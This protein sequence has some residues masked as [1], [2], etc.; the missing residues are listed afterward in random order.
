M[1][2][3]I[4]DG[5]SAL[6]GYAGHVEISADFQLLENTTAQPPEVMA[7]LCGVLIGY[8]NVRASS[9]DQILS[10][11]VVTETFVFFTCP[12]RD[13]Y[14]LVQFV[15]NKKLSE[16]SESVFSILRSGEN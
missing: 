4:S 8:L 14:L 16:A 1:R 3:N 6:A 5:L 13:G 10:F 7:E 9:K 11:S 15:K 12:T 2:R